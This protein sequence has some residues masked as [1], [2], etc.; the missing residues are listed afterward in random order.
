MANHKLQEVNELPMNPSLGATFL[1]RGNGI[2][3]FTHGI[4]KYPCKF[5]PHIPRWFLKKYSNALTNKL[6]VLDP[7]VGSG[8]T[9]VES[10]LL[11]LPSYGIDVDPL[12][13]LLSIVKTTRLSEK[14]IGVLYSI[15]DELKVELPKKNL[16]SSVLVKFTPKFSGLNYWFP[17][18]AITDLATIK[19]FLNKSAAKSKNKKI[20][21]FLFIVLASIIR[22]VSYAEEQSP[23]PYISKKIKKELPNVRIVFL[24][25]L[26]KYANA[27]T[28]FSR[29]TAIPA[30]KIIGRDARDIAMDS[31]PFGKV[32]LA[33]TSPPY[34]N[35]FDYVRSLKL[36]NFWLD[37]A[38]ED[39]L[40]KLYEQHIGTEKISAERYAKIKPE[41]GV[42]SLD[43]R[44]ARIYK[45]DKKRAHVVADYFNAMS[46]NLK[47]IYGALNKGGYYCIVVGDSKIKGVHIPT[48]RILIDIADAAG[49]QL[50]DDF[51]YIIRNRYLRIP[52]MG[53]GGLIK[54]DFILVFKK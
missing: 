35:A 15:V 20:E 25:N 14:E 52:R 46:Q 40:P 42:Q 43:E 18:K 23:K 5:I 54:K 34:I 9:L 50:V 45:L 32:H 4:F 49:F 41:S 33:M 31:L 29:K 17:Q 11:K 7:F 36:E 8:T 21:N 1:I 53:R 10:S 19:Y 6:G 47:A 13:K 2:T 51:S 30:A 12:S 22:K 24:D 16:S 39:D 26:A 44:L 28:L 27:V 48:S 37:L 3:D 38:S